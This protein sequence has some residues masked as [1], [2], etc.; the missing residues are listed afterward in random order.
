M[1]RRFFYYVKYFIKLC[2]FPFHLVLEMQAEIFQFMIFNDQKLLFLLLLPGERGWK[3]E[4]FFSLSKSNGAIFS[5][6]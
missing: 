5:L 1:L 3:E 6:K 2:L 4:F